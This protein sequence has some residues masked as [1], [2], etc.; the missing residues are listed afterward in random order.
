MLVAGLF[1][2]FIYKSTDLTFQIYR[3]VESPYQDILNPDGT[4]TI[5]NH[6]T[7]KVSHQGDVHHKLLFK[8]HDFD[9]QNKIEIVTPMIPFKV[10]SSEAKTMLFFKFSPDIINNGHKIIHLEVMEQTAAANNFIAILEVPLV[11]PIH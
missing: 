1:I 11:G 4:H 7:L 9:L 10:L 5:I 6:I 3:G 2:G 8:I